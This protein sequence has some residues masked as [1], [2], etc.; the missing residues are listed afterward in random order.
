MGMDGTRRADTDS[1]LESFKDLTHEYNTWLK[2]QV[3]VDL[4]YEGLRQEVGHLPGRYA[5]PKGCIFLISAPEED[6]SHAV[7]CAA[8]RPIAVEEGVCELKH[9]FVRPEHAGSG[10]GQ[11]LMQSCEAAAREMGYSKM[12]L[13]TLEVLGAANALYRGCGFAQTTAYKHNP[14]SGVVFYEKELRSP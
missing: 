2:M 13:E 4:S 9:L 11:A 12:M 10:L 5:A 8:V 7:G 3:G 14:L 6:I 1:D